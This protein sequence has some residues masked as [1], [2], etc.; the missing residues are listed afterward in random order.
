MASRMQ[1]GQVAQRTKRAHHGGIFS[2]VS[3]VVS[4]YSRKQRSVALSSAEVEYMAA[5]EAI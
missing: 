3:I 1:L 4:W 5:C 2:I